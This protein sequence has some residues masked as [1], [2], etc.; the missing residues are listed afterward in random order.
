MKPFLFI[1]ILS[2]LFMPLLVNNVYGLGQ[3]GGST[4][5]DIK[6]GEQDTFLWG[7]IQNKNEAITLEL[8]ADGEGAEFLSYPKS[9]NINGEQ[10]VYQTFEVNIPN[11]YPGGI[12]LRPTVYA[13]EYGADTGSTT[14]NIRMAKTITLKIELNDNPDLW[15]DWEALKAE[16]QEG[17]TL[18]SESAE[19]VKQPQSQGEPSES[20]TVVQQQSAPQ[21]QQKTPSSTTV[22]PPEPEMDP[23]PGVDFDVIL[24]P[25]SQALQID[26]PEGGG[27]LIATATYGSE[28]A[29]QVQLLREI[30][31]NTV[32]KTQSGT[33]FMTG[34]N[35]L[36]YSFSPTIA[37]WERQYPAFKELVK[38][39]IT[40][41]LTSLSILNSVNVDSEEEMLGY[42]IGIILL[43]VGMYF[44]APTV[45]II[46]LRKQFNQN[47]LPH[48][49]Q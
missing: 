11:D 16:Q 27:C 46:K 49:P 26:P 32:L 10:K 37:D 4:I 36:Y 13:I 24:D 7:L 31:D 34:F 45:L 25:E 5:I 43:N 14:I 35:Q 44:V 15:V 20:T 12:T 6:P 38:L 19:S 1:T 28:L 42:G 40:P 22:L 18:S 41:L 30:R 29:P 8:S 23:E 21:I 3:T 47:L 33:Y 17:Q 39:T 9:I 48:L 2:L